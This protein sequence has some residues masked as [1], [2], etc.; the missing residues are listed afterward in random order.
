MEALGASMLGTDKE[1]KGSRVALWPWKAAATA[2]VGQTKSQ[3]PEQW[4]EEPTGIRCSTRIV[5]QGR[6]ISFPLWEHDQACM[7]TPI[8]VPQML[9]PQGQQHKFNC[10]ASPL[11]ALQWLPRR[12]VKPLSYGVV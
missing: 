7:L 11:K 9:S 3:R 1:L 5:S 12:N 6:V 8:A 10:A 2:R 4:Q